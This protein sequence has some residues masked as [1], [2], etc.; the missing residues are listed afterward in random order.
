MR[1]PSDELAQT[2]SHMKRKASPSAI[3]ISSPAADG[4]FYLYFN[5]LHFGNTT[6][7]QQLAVATSR[8]LRN[9][10]VHGRIFAGEAPTTAP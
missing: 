2:V 3:R 9:W 4:N 1:K 10:K 8:D 7:D 6:N 5:F